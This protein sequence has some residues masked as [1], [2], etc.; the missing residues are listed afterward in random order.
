M[1]RHSGFTLI[2]LLVVIGIIGILAA[3]LLPAL[4]R[5]REAAR[6]AACQNNLKQ[7]GLV[8]KM[9]ANESSGGMLPTL[10]P[11]EPFQFDDNTQP[12]LPAACTWDPKGVEVYGDW[13]PDMRQIYPEYLSDLSVLECPSAVSYTGDAD[14]DLGVIRD[15]GTGGCPLNGHVT[16][17]DEDYQYYG[18]VLDSVGPTDST[19]LASEA[20]LGV[21]DFLVSAQLADLIGALPLNGMWNQD[22]SD[23]G[24]LHEDLPISE[25]AGLTNTGTA[26]GQLHMRLREGIERF[27]ITDINNPAGS[28][29][30]QSEL[31]IMWD[32]YSANSEAGDNIL[33]TNHLPGGS[34]VLYLDGH[35]AFEKFP[36]KFPAHAAAAMCIGGV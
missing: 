20:H 10:L 13:G 25:V 14:A 9:Y 3:I 18:F 15:D 24:G 5:A 31:P 2:E 11:D 33:I 28:G 35:V 36:G 30:A 27:L 26:W 21:G 1:K 32:F 22:S 23:D 19:I 17:S 8:F 29:K 4:S 6:R 7:M 34:N 16:N 12:I